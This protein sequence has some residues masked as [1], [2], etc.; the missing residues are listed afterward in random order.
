M[1]TYSPPLG[2]LNIHPTP[3]QKYKKEI[4]LNSSNNIIDPKPTR[5]WV[6]THGNHVVQLIISHQANCI[7]IH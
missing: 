6:E 2:A 1:I 4:K 5:N 7:H 3:T